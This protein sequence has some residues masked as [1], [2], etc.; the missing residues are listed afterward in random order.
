MN[1]TIDFA[2]RCVYNTTGD[3]PGSDDGLLVGGEVLSVAL[4]SVSKHNTPSTLGRKEKLTM[5][6]VQGKKRRN[7]RV[8]QT[9]PAN[10]T[11]PTTLELIVSNGQN[12]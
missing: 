4:M 5:L 7:E 2:M 9:T 8:L 6:N 10:A 11:R 3:S 1:H 12:K